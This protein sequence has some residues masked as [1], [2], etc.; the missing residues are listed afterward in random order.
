MK[1]RASASAAVASLPHVTTE[2]RGWS[3]SLG[4][5]LRTGCS[6]GSRG[7]ADLHQDERSE[8]SLLRSDADDRG[9]DTPYEPREE[10]PADARGVEPTL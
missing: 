1:R 4:L 10:R 2:T 6:H 8:A 5:R 7:A 3:R 9:G